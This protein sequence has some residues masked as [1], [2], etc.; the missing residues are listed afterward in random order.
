[1]RALELLYDGKSLTTAFS[2]S[3][4]GDHG[5]LIKSGYPAF[6]DGAIWLQTT[7]TESSLRYDFAFAGPPNFTV[8]DIVVWPDDA[9]GNGDAG[10]IDGSS[11]KSASPIVLDHSLRTVTASPNESMR[12]RIRIGQDIAHGMAVGVE[13]HLKQPDGSFYYAN[14]YGHSWFILKDAKPQDGVY[15]LDWDS[16]KR[17]LLPGIYLVKFILAPVGVRI[18]GNEKPAGTQELIVR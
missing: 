2:E 8:A 17:G 4:G 9:S 11:R 1:M 5:R 10:H 12:Y 3:A 16:E 6:R 18:V 14:G 13:L 7:G 15:Q